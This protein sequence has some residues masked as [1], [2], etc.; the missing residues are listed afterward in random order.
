MKLPDFSEFIPFRNLRQAMGARRP[1]HFVLFDPQRHLTGRERSEL[2]QQG[3]QLPLARLRRLADDTWGLKNTRLLVYRSDQ[4]YF[5]LAQC[6]VTQSWDP[7]TLIWVTTRRS[8]PLPLGEGKEIELGVCPECLQQLGYKGFDLKRNRKVGYSRLL[9][10][11]FSREDFFQV[12]ALYPLQGVQDKPAEPLL[13]M[14]QPDGP[15][16]EQSMPGQ[17]GS[18]PDPG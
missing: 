5:H 17:S 18:A 6:P 3:R 10:K 8:G 1:G 7:Q 15:T 4:P 16:T 14:P 9:L 2:D 12:F 11:Q 13:K